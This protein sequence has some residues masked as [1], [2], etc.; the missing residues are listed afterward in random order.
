VGSYSDASG[1]AL[2]Y[3]VKEKFLENS[4]RGFSE[5][6]AGNHTAMYLRPRKPHRKVTAVPEVTT[7]RWPSIKVR[8]QL[9]RSPGDPRLSIRAEIKSTDPELQFPIQPEA[10][11]ALLCAVLRDPQSFFLSALLRGRRVPLPV[12]AQKIQRPHC[13]KKLCDLE[14]RAQQRRQCSAW[15]GN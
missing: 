10:T 8:Q 15:I 13:D 12:A 2:S 7:I 1:A 11:G 4:L 5:V 14:G 6:P 3:L 9:R